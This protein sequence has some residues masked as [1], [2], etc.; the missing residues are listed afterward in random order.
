M[1]D[2]RLRLRP[3]FVDPVIA[4]S[5]NLRTN[6]PEAATGILVSDVSPATCRSDSLEEG[7]RRGE[8][9]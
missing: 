1:A 8:E 2:A 5:E 6:V 4:M 3:G 9:R 7:I